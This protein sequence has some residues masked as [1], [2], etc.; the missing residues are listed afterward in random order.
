MLEGNMEWLTNT[1]FLKKS[2]VFYCRLGG[3]LGFYADPY[4]TP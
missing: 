3:R 2:G 1:P 4:K